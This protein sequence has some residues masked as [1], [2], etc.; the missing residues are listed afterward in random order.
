M[1]KKKPTNPS[2]KGKGAASASAPPP[3]NPAPGSARP[4]KILKKKKKVKADPEKQ[5]AAAAEVAAT[6]TA[7]ASASAPAPVPVPAPADVSPSAA[8]VVA[9]N[10]GADG[11]TAAENN[12]ADGKMAA[13]NTGDGSKTA[14]ENK[15]D[16]SKTATDNKADGSK[17]IAQNNGDD[18]KTVTGKKGDARKTATGSSSADRK[19][20]RRRGEGHG[21]AEEKGKKDEEERS[22]AGFIFMCNA[23]TKPECFQNSVFGL[24]KGKIDVVEKIRTGAK[25]FLY[26]FDLKLLYG[27][28]KATA[29]GKMDLVRRAFN[30][31]FPAQV[32]FKIDKDCLPL[33]ESSFK[34]AIKE[35]YSS[36]GKFTPQLNSRQVRKLLALYK[37]ISLHRSSLQHVEESHRVE[38][39]MPRYVDERR[40]PHDY[41]ERRLSRH[42]EDERRLLRHDEEVHHPRFVEERRLG[43]A[44][45][46][47]RPPH[48]VEEIRRAQFVQEVHAPTHLPESQYAPPTYYRHIAPAS[49]DL[50]HPHQT[51]MIYERS[52]VDA[53]NRDP[54]LAREYRGPPPAE[55]A[56]RSDHVDELYRSYKLVTR[57]QGLRQDPP[58]A[59]VAYE[60]PRAPY[61]EDIQQRPVSTRVPVSS[62]YSFAGA[63]AY[64]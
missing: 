54:Y 46:E 52:P 60:N 9:E 63:P 55:F 21:R 27:V 49:N 45:E 10:N 11:K 17:A 40:Q 51:N 42:D 5:K 31:R 23:K 16:G 53:A 4:K 8:P 26:D 18:R 24:P 19:K 2:A 28:Y 50:Y 38:R 47:R 14:A 59:P 39:R 1:V 7:E 35:N 43:Y 32:K 36:K 6:A 58:Y 61:P 22:C 64:R 15:G 34:H 41:E 33:P 3:P 30:G 12:G 57:P 44:Y 20:E 48:H 13:E 37:P 56:A 62:L 25:L 29:R